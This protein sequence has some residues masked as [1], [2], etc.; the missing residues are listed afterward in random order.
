[1]E[2]ELSPPEP[3]TQEYILDS[4]VR[5]SLRDLVVKHGL[6]PITSTTPTITA[7]LRI[8]Y[9]MRLESDARR[10]IIEEAIGRQ[11]IEIFTEAHRRDHEEEE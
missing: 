8:M 6:I 10:D 5:D 9:A 1:M 11:H 7:S 3:I 4:E 2:I